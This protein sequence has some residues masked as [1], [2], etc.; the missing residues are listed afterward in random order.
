MRRGLHVWI[1]D[2]PGFVT[3]TSRPRRSIREQAALL[4]HWL[5]A[6]GCRPARLLGNSTPVPSAHGG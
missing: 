5:A 6:I 1:L 2:P 3:A 4:P